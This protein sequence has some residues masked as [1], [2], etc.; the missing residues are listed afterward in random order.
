MSKE[1]GANNGTNKKIFERFMH[2]YESY[3]GKKVFGIAY[4]VGAAVVIV[5]ALFKIT[6][7]P[8]ANIVLPVG[9]IVEALLFLVGCLDKPHTEYHW[10]NVF[11]QLLEYGTDPALLEEMKSR[12]KPTLLGGAN[13]GASAS[14]NAT[15]NTIV[16]TLSVTEMAELKHGIENLSKTAEQ[17]TE[18]SKVATAT[19]QLTSKLNLAE[20][21][22]DQFVNAG[23]EMAVNSANFG[24]VY[25][26]VAD[27]MQNVVAG[28]NEYENQVLSVAKQLSNLNAIYE[29]QVNAVQKQVDAVKTQM[30]TVQKVNAQYDVLNDSVKQMSALASESLKCQEVYNTNSKLLVQQVADL[31]KVYGNMLNALV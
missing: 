13:V 31:N 23:K 28:T 15:T 20:S 17:L 2:W 5:G 14:S 3:Q 25:A 18:L 9:M 11:P 29:L 6:H 1:N 19:T 10:N 21:A 26:K 16:P 30:E 7:W 27:Q 12:P 4:S 8:G 24:V 22:V